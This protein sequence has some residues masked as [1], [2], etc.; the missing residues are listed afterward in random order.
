MHWRLTV[1]PDG[2]AAENRIAWV[3]VLPDEAAACTHWSTH[4]KQF[5]AGR[6]ARAIER[7]ESR[8]ACDD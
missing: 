6:Y 1:A 2:G 8:L 3:H 7:A 4:R 5:P